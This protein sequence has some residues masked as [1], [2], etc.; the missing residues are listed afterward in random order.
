ML[1]PPIKHVGDLQVSLHVGS[2][3]TGVRALLKAVSFCGMH[4]PLGLPC[5]SSVEED[6]L[7]SVEI[8]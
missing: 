1:R 2:P 6:V 3:K 7:N 4:Y 8:S 5:L